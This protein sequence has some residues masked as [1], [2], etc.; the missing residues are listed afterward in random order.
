MSEIRPNRLTPEMS[1]RAA[2][3]VMASMASSGIIKESE[4]EGYAIDLAKHGDLHMDGYAIAKA[5]DSRC[6][7]DCDLQMAEELDMFSSE[8]E[9]EITDAQK[10]WA[11]RNSIV[12]QFDVGTRVWLPKSGESGEITGI[13]E[14]GV[15]KFLVKMDGGKDT[16]PPHNARRIVNF[17]DAAES[18]T[19]DG[20][21]S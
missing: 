2:Q 8:A 18:A 13:Y 20:P 17:E 12:P 1:L 4:I 5:L 15:A 10:A 14:Y 11:E 16:E 19:V 9:A 7:W 6:Y 3:R 21:Q